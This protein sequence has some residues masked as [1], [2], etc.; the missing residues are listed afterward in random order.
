MT[1]ILF[2]R[3]LSI[4]I[5]NIIS[6]VEIIKKK[7]I[8][9]ILLFVCIYLFLNLYLFPTYAL[10]EIDPDLLDR[11]NNTYK[12]S[13]IIYETPSD[14]YTEADREDTIETLDFLIRI[15]CVALFCSVLYTLTEMFPGK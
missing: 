13:K 11:E 8:K 3:N 12:G 9:Q 10:C 1:I 2:I 5:L 7:N 4:T 6:L 14:I 15:A